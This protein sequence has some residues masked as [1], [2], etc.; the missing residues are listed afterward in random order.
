MLPYPGTDDYLS[1]KRFADTITEQAFDVF[2]IDKTHK[3]VNAVRIG[4]P[5]DNP[6]G[7]PLEIRSI[8][9]GA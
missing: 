4:C 6:Q 9:Y 5:A 3:M 2:V 7:E 8:S 1:D